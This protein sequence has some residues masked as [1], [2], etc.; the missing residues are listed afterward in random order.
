PI[1]KLNLLSA[2]R[3]LLVVTEADKMLTCWSDSTRVT[4]A[5]S[6]VRS[7]ASTWMATRNTEAS[8]GAQCTVTI[9]SFCVCVRWA[10]FTQSARCTDTPWPW[11]TNPWISSPGTGVQHLDSRTQTSETP[12]TSTPESLGPGVR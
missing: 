1:S 5:S 10:R 6:L 8:F 4:S 9:R 12:S 11:V 7:R 2:T 3:S